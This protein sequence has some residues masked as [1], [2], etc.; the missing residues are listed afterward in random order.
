[1]PVGFIGLGNRQANGYA[2]GAIVERVRPPL[3]SA[4]KLIVPALTTCV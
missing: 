1:M 4:Q 3:L 2:L